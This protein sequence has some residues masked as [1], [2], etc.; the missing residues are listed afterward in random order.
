MPDEID[1][2]QECEAE[3]LAQQLR[4]QQRKRA[5]QLKTLPFCENRSDGCA[6]RAFVTEKGTV[7]RFCRACWDEFK[8]ERDCS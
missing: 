2:A 3:F 5:E 1:H 7:A 4:A 6:E 8:Q